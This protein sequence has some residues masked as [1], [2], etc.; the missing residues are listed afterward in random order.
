[1]LRVVSLPLL[2]C[3][4]VLLCTLLLAPAP[5]DAKLDAKTWKAA[6]AEFE[7]LFAA[8]GQG[9][10]KLAVLETVA[11]DGT[12]R[13]WKLLTGGLV[14]QVERMEAIRAEYAKAAAVH[15]DILLATLRGYSPGQE[16]SAK[17]L[18]KQM[19]S[20]ETA[21]REDAQVLEK[22]Q[23]VFAGAP[24][25]VRRSVLK[26]AKPKASV[27]LRAAVARVAGLGSDD[28]N[29]LNHVKKVLAKDPAGA[30][31][32]AALDGL[33]RREALSEKALPLIVARLADED[34]DVVQAAAKTLAVHPSG[35]AGSLLRKAWDGA[36]WL[37]RRD[38]GAAIEAA[39]A[40][41]PDAE[42]K[43]WWAGR[44]QQAAEARVA[45]IPLTGKGVLFVLDVSTYMKPELKDEPWQR[46]PAREAPKGKAPPPELG[47]SGSRLA[48]AIHE[49]QLAI[50]KLPESTL[51]NLLVF[52]HGAALWER[53]M[54][55]AT[56][57]HK[58]EARKW[59]R[60]RKASGAAYLEGSLRLVFRL[61]GAFAGDS[62][63]S[64]P[65]IDTVVILSAGTTTDNAFPTHRKVEPDGVQALARTWNAEARLV[66]HTVA[67]GT[68]DFLRDLA[69]AHGGMHAH[70]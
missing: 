42:L 26:L 6:A 49:L 65:Q 29:A 64:M 5:A 28:R 1:M 62:E 13:A 34:A 22:I 31:R 20:L 27:A 50:R 21:E 57:E 7:K 59:L 61:V 44:P 14:T 36:S 66:I 47:L 53:S 10:A 70:R 60:E 32:S 30:V 35:D 51:F 37:A 11:S 56:K 33:R 68:S 17:D 46:I 63:A 58:D 67:M 25:N 4:S 48:V 40:K 19:R 69:K 24:S 12:A 3:S 45:T 52:N 8:R 38:V 23:A 55:P 41:A 2:L 16:D 15:G 9:D 54:Q 39:L 18:Q 43:A